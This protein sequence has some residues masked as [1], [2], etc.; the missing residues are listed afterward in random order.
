MI[1][2]SKISQNIAFDHPKSCK[3][4]NS[5]V[6]QNLVI[7]FKHYSVL[8]FH[9]CYCK[10]YQNEKIMEEDTSCVCVD[11]APMSRAA[12]TQIRAPPPPQQELIHGSGTTVKFQ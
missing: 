11:I 6:S 3:T 4:F 2:I 7:L 9:R 10:P 5:K 8:R 1:I 12:D